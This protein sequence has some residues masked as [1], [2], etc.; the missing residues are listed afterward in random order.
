MRIGRLFDTQLEFTESD[1]AILCSIHSS[2][3][4]AAMTM[5]NCCA[6]SVR[7]HRDSTCRFFQPDC[8]LGAPKKMLDRECQSRRL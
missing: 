5:A 2:V 8:S 4:P 3:L 1:A 6:C 7:Q